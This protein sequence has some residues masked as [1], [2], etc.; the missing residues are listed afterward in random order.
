MKVSEVLKLSVQ[1]RFWYWVKERWAVLQ[2]RLKGLPK[3][4]TDDEILQTCFFCNVRRRDDKTTVWIEDWY[5]K[6]HVDHGGTLAPEAFLLA[7]VLARQINWPDC[8]ATVGFPYPWEPEEVR[9]AIEA[10]K[11]R[12]EK[13]YSNAYVV[14]ANH[15]PRGREKQEKEYQTVYLVCDPI[16]KAI[17]AGFILDMG[18]MEGCW[19]QIQKFPGLASFMAGQVV[20]DLRLALPYDDCW[21]DKDTWAPVGPGSSRGVCLYFDLPLTENLKQEQWKPYFDDIVREAHA[22]QKS[23]SEGKFMPHEVEGIDWQNCLCEF[24]KYERVLADPTKSRFRYPG[25]RDVK[26]GERHR[27]PA[28]VDILGQRDKFGSRKYRKR[29]QGQAEGEGGE[30]GPG[31]IPAMTPEHDGSDSTP[32]GTMIQDVGA[33]FNG[34]GTSHRPHAVR[35]SLRGLLVELLQRLPAE[36]RDLVAL[37]LVLRAATD[38][39]DVLEG[40]EAGEPSLVVTLAD[41]RVL[42]PQV[43]GHVAGGDLG[44]RGEVVLRQNPLFLDE[45]AEHPD[46]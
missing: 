29:G 24:F 14:S 15:G 44:L 12:G 31:G 42:R 3:P 2:R 7:A 32:A 21:A 4:W 8:L 41:N 25:D 13:C 34:T 39:L 45:D 37:D 1:D 38:G 6:A 26:E 27:L 16:A 43:L 36:G 9:L 35:P 11:S 18:T 20:A 46:L 30:G 22:R 10:R 33:G 17:D 23:P 28:L 5:R 19:R 40:Q